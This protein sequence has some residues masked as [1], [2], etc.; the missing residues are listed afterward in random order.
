[1]KSWRLFVGLSLFAVSGVGAAPE[2]QASQDSSS[3]SSAS[4]PASGG[5]GGSQASGHSE[6]APPPTGVGG[7]KSGPPKTAPPSESPVISGNPA[8]P[9]TRHPGGPAAAFRSPGTRP[10]VYPL[11][12]FLR[13]GPA[14]TGTRPGTPP[15]SG[16]RFGFDRKGLRGEVIARTLNGRGFPV[17][18]PGRG[19]GALRGPSPS[20]LGPP[21]S[22]GPF[23]RS[24][25][26]RASFP[27]SLNGTEIRVP[28][29]RLDASALGPKRVQAGA[30]SLN[31]TEIRRK[32]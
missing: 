30:A 24:E 12:D 16:L 11:R 9:R 27:G 8:N 18:S 32:H 1:M 4:G 14:V 13:R 22:L 25:P 21:L 26:S 15:V 6:E 3:K 20:R 29:T 17:V 19:A 23:H 10:R 2:P 7:T 5:A 28:F 31:G